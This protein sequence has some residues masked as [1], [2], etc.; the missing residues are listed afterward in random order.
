MTEIYDWSPMPHKVDV[1]C[2]RC[3]RC[4][5]FEF[6]EVCRIKLKSDV[7]FFKNNSMFEYRQFQDSCGHYWHGA[8]YYAGL[9]GNP[10]VALKRLPPNYKPDEWDHSEYLYRSHGLDIGSIHCEHCHLKTKHNLNWPGDAY[11]S[12]AYRN[13][14]LW[15]FDRE[16]ACDLRDFIL[17][18]TRDISKYRW[19]LFLSHIPTVFKTQKAREAVSK[20]LLRLLAGTP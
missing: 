1:K 3:K 16:S 17:S 19:A 2:P 18:K 13:N 11:Y 15:A 8:V 14:V 9:H 7:D 20:H 5:Q 4:A 6:A 10:R 12:V